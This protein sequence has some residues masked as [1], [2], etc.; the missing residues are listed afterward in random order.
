MD[1]LYFL[2]FQPSELMKIGVILCLAKYYHR[3]SIEK[4]N[5]FISISF[6]LTI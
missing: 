1:N 3:I 6:A 4:V 2:V 5:S